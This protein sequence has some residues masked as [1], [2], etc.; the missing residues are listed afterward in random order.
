M[1]FKAEKLDLPVKRYINFNIRNY[2]Q[3]L[4]ECQALTAHS[5]K[6][7]LP[8]SGPFSQILSHISFSNKCPPNYVCILL[9]TL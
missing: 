8:R 2:V 5:E 9:T 4:V 6:T 7:I 1:V 3:T